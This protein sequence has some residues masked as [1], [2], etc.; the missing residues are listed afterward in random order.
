MYACVP[1]TLPGLRLALSHQTGGCPSPEPSCSLR[2]MPSHPHLEV[3]LQEVSKPL[4]SPH[5]LTFFLLL[6]LH[7]IHFGCHLDQ[8]I[9]FFFL[10][11]ILPA[12]G[13]IGFVICC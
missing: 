8:G 6:S 3:W 11:F 12:S 9:F 13:E 7:G 10:P 2:V 4:S 5:P 1:L